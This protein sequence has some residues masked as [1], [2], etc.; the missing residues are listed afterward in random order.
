MAHAIKEGDKGWAL[1]GNSR[2]FHYYRADSRSA[3]GKYLAFL[4]PDEAFTTDDGTL[5]P[6]SDDCAG[7]WKKLP[8]SV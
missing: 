6:N 7:C 5:T 4:A 3:C 1:L 8:E 2:K